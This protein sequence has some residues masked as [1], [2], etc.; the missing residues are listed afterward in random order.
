MEKRVIYHGSMNIV[1]K[2]EIRITKFHKDFYF[3][4]YCTVLREQAQRWATRFGN[5]GY[6]NIYDNIISCKYNV[7]DYWDIGEVFERLIEDSYDEDSYINGIFEIH[8]SWIADK[9]LNFNSDFFY[10]PRD[11]I[12]MCYKEG[13]VLVS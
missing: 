10:Q 5:D 7:P 3:G 12:A 4:F 8:H 6:I 1:S 11:Y 13:K 9:I 2:P